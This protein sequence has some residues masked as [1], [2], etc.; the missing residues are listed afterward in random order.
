MCAE[1]DGIIDIIN[2]LTW[3]VVQYFKI[4]TG[5]DIYDIAKIAKANQYALGTGNNDN[6]FKGGVQI[7][8]IKR[9]ENNL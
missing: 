7:I 1:D 9:N 4:S 6:K 8:E 3:K 5:I 2:V